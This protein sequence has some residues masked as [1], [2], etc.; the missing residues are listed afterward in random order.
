MI[1]AFRPVVGRAHPIEAITLIPSGGG[2][3]EVTVDDEL[4]YSKAMTGQHTTNDFIIAR[5]KKGLE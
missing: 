1:A 5:I 2:R 4:I 3:Y